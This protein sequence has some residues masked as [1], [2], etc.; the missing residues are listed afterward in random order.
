MISIDFFEKIFIPSREGM[1]EGSGGGEVNSGPDPA[2]HPYSWGSGIWRGTHGARRRLAP[3][4]H[5]EEGVDNGE[6]KLG[7]GRR[8]T[9]I[10]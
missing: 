9:K 6:L 1:V 3:G 7:T 8:P 10:K 5:L 2:C 4:T